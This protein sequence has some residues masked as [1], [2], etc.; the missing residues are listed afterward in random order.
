MMGSLNS[1]CI[2]NHTLIFFLKKNLKLFLP[3]SITN[4]V[5]NIAMIFLSESL[6][7]KMNRRVVMQPR[8]KRNK[9][10]VAA[11]LL[12]GLSNVSS[13]ATGNFKVKVTTL[14]D[15]QIV[16]ETALNFGANVLTTAGNSCTLFGRAPS[17]ADAKADFDGADGDSGA[18]NN[19]TLSG[20]ACVAGAIG[21]AGIYSLEG[22]Q[23][24]SAKVTVSSVDAG[25]FTFAPDS[26]C[27]VNFNNVATTNESC[28]GLLPNTPSSSF[29]F[30]DDNAGDRNTNETAVSYEQ[31][32]TRVFVGGTIAVVNELDPNKAYDA[33]FTIEVLYD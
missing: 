14:P 10:L 2:K 23:G 26:S 4:H 9:I 20:A 11:A 1:K 30:S 17:E 6:L 25:D 5:R 24:Q 22:L 27:V 21:T 31:N 32:F 19:G 15:V 29:N 33:D 12:M 7:I 16:Q 3:S 8:L 18:G 13:A 28:I